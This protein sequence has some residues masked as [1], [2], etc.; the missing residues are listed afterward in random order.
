MAVG[1]VSG[2]V[3]TQPGQPVFVAGT[4]VGIQVIPEN[5]ERPR[6]VVPTNAGTQPFARQCVVARHLDLQGAS[7]VATNSPTPQ[8]VSM[9]VKCTVKCVSCW[10]SRH[11]EWSH[12]A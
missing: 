10:C 9:K 8:P 2:S 11:L 3:S 5:T 12:L 4:R 6:V 1:S 7:T